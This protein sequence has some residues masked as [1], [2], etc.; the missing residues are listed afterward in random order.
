[1]VS[2]A[3]ACRS[4]GVGDAASYKRAVITVIRNYAAI[5]SSADLFGTNGKIAV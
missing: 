5:Q 4:R 2:D 3:V 1:V